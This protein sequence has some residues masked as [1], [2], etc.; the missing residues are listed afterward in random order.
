MRPVLELY[1]RCDRTFWRGKIDLLRSRS[2][3]WADDD[4]STHSI[5]WYLWPTIAQASRRE[6]DLG[7][8]LCLTRPPSVRQMSSW[9]RYASASRSDRLVASL[10]PIRNALNNSSPSQSYE[11]N[12]CGNGCKLV[13]RFSLCHWIFLVAGSRPSSKGYLWSLKWLSCLYHVRLCLLRAY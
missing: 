11:G 7:A 2:L 12:S 4:L 9:A 6:S 8:T 10:P 13:Y 1:T 3:R 5:S